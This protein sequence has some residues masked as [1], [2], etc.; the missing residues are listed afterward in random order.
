VGWLCL[1]T[2]AISVPGGEPKTNAEHVELPKPLRTV[3]ESTQPLN[4]PRGKRLPLYVL[5]I[6]GALRDLDDNAVKA[7][8]KQLAARGIGYT[9]PWNPTDQKKV[10]A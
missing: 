5:P 10:A 9:V 3:L 2:A 7:A 1:I 8:L 4:L 6:S